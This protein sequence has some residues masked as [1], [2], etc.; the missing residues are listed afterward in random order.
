VSLPSSLRVSGLSR[1]R[2]SL[3]LYFLRYFLLPFPLSFRLCR[4]RALPY[5]YQDA[6]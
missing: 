2:V 3:L 6:C 4:R 5:E 1:L